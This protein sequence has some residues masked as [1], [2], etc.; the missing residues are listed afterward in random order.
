MNVKKN[1]TFIVMLWG[2]FIC[3]GTCG[4]DTVPRYDLSTTNKGVIHTITLKEAIAAALIS[5]LDIQIEA[6][7]P[8][9]L[10]HKTRQSK[11]D[12]DPAFEFSSRYETLNTPQ[13][14]QEFVSTG[15]TRFANGQLFGETRLFAEDNLENRAG[16]VGKLP[17]GTEYDLSVRADRFNN[18]L[19]RDRTVSPFDNEYRGFTGLKLKQPL[20]RDFG[21]EINFAKIMVAQKDKKIGDYEFQIQVARVIRQTIDAYYDSYLAYENLKAKRFEVEVLQ[22]LAEEK[23]DLLERGGAAEETVALVQS[24]LAETYERFLLCRQ[25]LLTKNGDLAI[26]IH[27]DFDFDRFPVYLATDKPSASFPHM[28]PD[29]LMD[30][31]I[32][33]RPEYLAAVQ[34]V[35]KYGI[36]LKYRKNQLRPRIDLEATLGHLSLD[37]EFGDSIAQTVKRQGYEYGVGVSVSV[38][39]QRNEEIGLLSET[40]DLRKKAVLKVKQE[41]LKTQMLINRHLSSIDIHRQ[42]IG[43]SQKSSELQK[44]NLERLQDNLERGTITEASL[45]DAQRDLRN[46][47]LR[48]YSA[49]ADLQRSLADLRFSTGILLSYYDVEIWRGD[50]QQPASAHIPIVHAAPVEVSDYR[51]I[52][53]ERPIIGR[54]EKKSNVFAGLF[55]RSK[56][57]TPISRVEPDNHERL[58]F[59]NSIPIQASPVAI[60][61]TPSAPPV[62]EK[63][64]KRLFRKR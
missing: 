53:M 11:G 22:Q 7:T 42:R 51:A 43:A 59:E 46:S 61:A 4:S 13:S 48:Q 36:V 34:D 15:G 18:D 14:S 8:Q 38:P 3:Y 54:G 27:Q 33:S 63:A 41:E 23:I 50:E 20:M 57:Q 40:M 44:M 47:Q 52:T 55:K 39:L 5:N 60:Q 24:S 30:K 12:F 21:R 58:D 64:T 6:I 45:L 32:K 31:A 62:T 16:I 26:L 17:T 29:D 37:G 35:E 28:S 10:D 2:I 49:A 56:K 19:T 9:I 1:H 25:T